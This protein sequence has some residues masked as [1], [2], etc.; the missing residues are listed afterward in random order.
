MQATAAAEQ[1]LRNAIATASQLA[2][3]PPSRTYGRRD[4]QN[5]P[6][7]VFVPERRA[8][9]KPAPLPEVYH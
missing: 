9:A 5:V 3:S 7:Q 4:D 2:R 6:I 1:Q 8:A